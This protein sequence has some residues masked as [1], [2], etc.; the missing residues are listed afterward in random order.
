M[1]TLGHIP[2]EWFKHLKFE[3]YDSDELWNFVSKKKTPLWFWEE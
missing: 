3:S 1:T 2:T